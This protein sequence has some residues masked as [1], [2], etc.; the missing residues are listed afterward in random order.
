VLVLEIELEKIPLVRTGH[1]QDAI[2]QARRPTQ[3]LSGIA[4]TGEL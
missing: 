2:L 1:G 3:G 4:D